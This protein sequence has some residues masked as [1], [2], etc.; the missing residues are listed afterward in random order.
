MPNP[1]PNHPQ[2]SPPPQRHTMAR[3]VVCGG[4]LVDL[5]ARPLSRAVRLARGD[6]TPGTLEQTFGGVGRNIAE[7]MGRMGAAPAL[8]CTVGA[9]AHGAALLAHAKAAGVDVSGAERAPLGAA[10]STYTCLLDGDGEV[11]GAVADTR[12][13]EAHAASAAALAACAAAEVVVLDANLPAAALAALGAAARPDAAVWFEPTSAAKA[14]DRWATARAFATH[15][16]PNAAELAAMCGGG[17]DPAAVE[18]CADTRA[19]AVEALFEASPRLVSCLV[20]LGPAGVCVDG[21]AALVPPAL[22]D[23]RVVSATGAGDCFAAAAALA[24]RAGRSP[25]EAAEAGSRAAAA[26]LGSAS[27]VPEDL[28]QT[29]GSSS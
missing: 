12:A 28:G 13:V 5:T 14:A 29:W 22:G 15:V 25:V 4:A 20:T 1:N 7:A 17:V 21:G 9:D 11:V 2:Q 16:T 18:A 24:T 8:F 6:S 3:L 19:R 27:A 10:T 26:A 23:G